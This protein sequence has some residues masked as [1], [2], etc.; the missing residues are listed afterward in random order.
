MSY[1]VDVIGN[2]PLTGKQRLLGR[3]HV[4]DGDLRIEAAEEG[5]LMDTL[6]QIVPD[7]D[8]GEDPAAFVAALPE[9]MD[10]TYVIASAQHADEECPF[11]ALGGEPVREQHGAH[12]HV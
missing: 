8:P 6:R 10:S 7:I 4:E 1:H 9:R 3:V 5:T 11:D 12:T 2:E